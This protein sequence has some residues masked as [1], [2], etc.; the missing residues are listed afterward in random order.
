V[1]KAALIE[2]EVG[3]VADALDEAINGKCGCVKA[4][5]GGF[6]LAFDG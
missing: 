5:F 2:F 6:D 1:T 4:V 3:M